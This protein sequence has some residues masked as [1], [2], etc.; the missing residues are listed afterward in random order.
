[1]RNVTI[2]NIRNYFVQRVIILKDKKINKSYRLLNYNSIPY[3]CFL[4]IYKI[5]QSVMLKNGLLPSLL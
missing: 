3:K 1:M 4:S 5:T 2:L